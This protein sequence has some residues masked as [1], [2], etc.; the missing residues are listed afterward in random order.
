MVFYFFVGIK[1][2]EESMMKLFLV[3]GQNYIPSLWDPDALCRL[4]F[5]LLFHLFS[6]LFLKILTS[7]QNLNKNHFNYRRHVLPNRHPP[8]LIIYFPYPYN[9]QMVPPPNDATAA[10]RAWPNLIFIRWLPSQTLAQS[11]REARPSLLFSGAT[12]IFKPI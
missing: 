2:N 11:K 4:P 1:V 12:P 6:K 7:K 9:K 5:L 10:F 3:M 8:S